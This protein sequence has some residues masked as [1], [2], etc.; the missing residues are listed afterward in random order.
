MLPYWPLNAY[1]HADPGHI[2]PMSLLQ[3]VLLS[4]VQG[5]TEWLPI[6]SSAHLILL[7]DLLGTEDQG[8][9]IDAMAHFGTLFAML[10][11]F[12]K[13]VMRAITGGL[14]LLGIG[15][16]PGNALSERAR[17]ALFILIATPF[18]IVAGLAF[19][20]SGE[21]TRAALRSPETIAMATIVFALAL[22]AADL[23]SKRVRM[24]EDMQPRDAMLI[25]ASQMLAFIPGT[26]RS[27][28]TMTAALALGFKRTEAARFAMLV[29][30][31]LIFAVG[32]RAVLGLATGEEAGA[33]L[34]DGMIV[35][36]LSFVSG[37]VS[38]WGLMALL[39]RMS[40][41]PFVV[42][43]L[44]L[45]GFLLVTSPAVASLFT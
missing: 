26:S 11:Y 16:Q 19:E 3:L 10:L 37:Y 22:W 13:D 42:Y 7:P 43:R 38:I 2:T 12:R 9:L 32:M 33:S 24:Q 35:A 45:G 8:P 44:V 20:L 25:G 14:E 31:P 41:L 39:E 15:R 21:A 28:I 27:G 6:S 17:L 18:G 29:G 5:I 34:S 40:F 23:L 36:G 30:A 4:L 1:A